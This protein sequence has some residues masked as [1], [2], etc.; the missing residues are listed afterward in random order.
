MVSL[1]MQGIKTQ[2][3]T[4]FG[5]FPP[6]PKVPES[7][8]TNIQGGDVSSLTVAEVTAQRKGRDTARCH[9]VWDVVFGSVRSDGCQ[10]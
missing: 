10:M 3:T 8:S 6:H 4:I 9:G 7:P 5:V 2:P 1:E